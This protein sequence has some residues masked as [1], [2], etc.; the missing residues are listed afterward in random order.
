VNDFPQS[1]KVP[2]AMLKLGI[3]NKRLGSDVKAQSWFNQLIKQYPDSK[4][5]QSAQQYLS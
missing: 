4:A 3:I 1:N 5:A 2:D